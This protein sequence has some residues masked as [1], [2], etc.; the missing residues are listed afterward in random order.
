MILKSENEVLKEEAEKLRHEMKLLRRQQI[1]S[2]ATASTQKCI[3]LTN[4]EEISDDDEIE[5]VEAPRKNEIIEIEDDE[6]NEV[7]STSSFNNNSNNNLIESNDA[8]E[9]NQ[10]CHNIKRP[11]T[12]SKCLNEDDYKIFEDFIMSQI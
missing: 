10:D 8:K 11:E 4:E 12:P 2:S 3:D 9:N 5:I 7:K 1:K 6:E